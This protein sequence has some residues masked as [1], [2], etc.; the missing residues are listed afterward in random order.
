[1]IKRKFGMYRLG[2]I[3]PIQSKYNVTLGQLNNVI[4]EWIKM[5][6]S[7]NEKIRFFDKFGNIFRG[8]M[9]RQ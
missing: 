7:S 6:S 3:P 8:K 2:Y 5:D 9:I 4:E 1:M